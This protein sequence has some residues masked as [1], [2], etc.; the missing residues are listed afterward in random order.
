MFARHSS[1]RVPQEGTP[2][3]I[4]RAIPEH[5]I[6]QLDSFPADTHY[7]DLDP[8]EVRT[9]FRA[10]YV[11]PR[12]CDRRPTEVASLPKNCLEREG[13]ARPCRRGTRAHRSRHPPA[14]TRAGRRAVRRLAGQPGEPEVRPR[15]GA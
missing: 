15:D 9:M 1:H 2:D 3:E 8:D 6:R 10:V 13:L 11:V 5:V 7:G 4:G 12:D 14:G